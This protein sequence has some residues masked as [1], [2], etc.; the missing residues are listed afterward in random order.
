MFESTST[1]ANVGL[2]VW[3]TAP[4]MP[5]AMKVFA[6]LQMWLGRLEFMAGFALV[7]WLYA[8]WRGKG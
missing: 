8:T 4:S 5:Y 1:L 6:I 3:I 2:S 7:G